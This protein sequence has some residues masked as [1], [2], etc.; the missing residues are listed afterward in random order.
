MAKNLKNNETAISITPPDMRIIELKIRGIS[1]LSIHRFS[2]KAKIQMKNAQEAGLTSKSKKA[3]DPKDFEQEYRD[4]FYISEDGWYGIHAVSF[5]NAAIGACRAVGYR[6]THAK[7]ALFI[8]H[9]G[10]DKEDG[11]PLVR[12]TDGEPE[13]WIAPVKNSNAGTDLRARPLWRKWGANLR[14]RYD[15][16][17][18]TDA[19]VVNLMARA[20][21]QGGIGEGRP[22]SK[23]SAGLGFGLFEI[24]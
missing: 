16:G 9:D 5:R 17:M 12:I 6:M 15:A 14:I 22:S 13:L 8:V 23:L 11:T 21:I 7:L 4:A 3:R 20:G 10:I 1:P 19:D 2:Q 18:F 24:V